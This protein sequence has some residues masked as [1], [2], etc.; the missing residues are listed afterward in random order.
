MLYLEGAVGAF[1]A[2]CFAL[3]RDNAVCF[4]AIV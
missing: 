2:Y 4:F 3:I 1:N